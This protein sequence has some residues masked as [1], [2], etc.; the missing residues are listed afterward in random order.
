MAA[1]N[2][3]LAKAN[4]LQGDIWRQAVAAVRTEGAPLQ[5]AVLVLPALNAMIDI[6]TTR[7]MAAQLHPPGVVYFML[8]ALPLACALPGGLRHG[9]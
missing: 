4:A 8:F 5:A 3:Q 9:R 1:V 7:T 6:T 2:K